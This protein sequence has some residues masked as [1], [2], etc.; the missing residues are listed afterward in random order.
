MQVIYSP[1]QQDH[2]PSSFITSGRVAPSPECPERAERFLAAVTGAGHDVAAPREHGIGP[3]AAI[4]PPDYLRFL[5]TAH[6]RW[7]ALPNPGPEVIPNVHP[8]RHMVARPAHVIGQAG[9]FMAD[10]AC[11]VGEGTWRAARAA[12]DCAVTA[13]DLVLDG[14]GPAYAL[15]RPP[16]HHAFADMAGGFCFLNNAGIAAARAAA[17]GRRVAILD[18]DVHHGN[19]TQ[20]IF[21]RRSDVFFVSV[22][23]D[24]TNYYPF[25]SGYAGERGEGPGEGYNLNLPQAHGTGDDGYLEAIAEGLGA[26][27]RYGADLLVLSLGLDPQ[28]N[29]PLGVLKV[30]TEGFR[31]AGARVAG[32]RLDTL[33]VQEGGYLCDELG[34]NLAAF[35]DGFGNG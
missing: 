3:V 18:I 23:A 25:F 26:V 30:T 15:C 27:A 13:M 1:V 21:Y 8:G 20:G 24:P 9:Y 28:E 14:A 32:A 12:A 7:S 4:H 16:G 34:A 11:P 19:G 29:D 31:K 2:D 5:E 6:A 33:I 35:L 10:T 22:H 17:G